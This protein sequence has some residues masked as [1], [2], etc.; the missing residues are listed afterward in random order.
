MVLQQEQTQNGEQKSLRSFSVEWVVM[1]FSVNGPPC[2]LPIANTSAHGMQLS[3]TIMKQRNKLDIFTFKI[4][5][6]I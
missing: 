1:L 4:L 6:N 2:N 3:I 5:P